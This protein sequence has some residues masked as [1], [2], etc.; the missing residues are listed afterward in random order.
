MIPPLQQLVDRAQHLFDD[1][2]LGS[3]H[4][5]KAGGENRKAVGHMPI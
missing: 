1:I 4:A 5:W 2:D 3:V